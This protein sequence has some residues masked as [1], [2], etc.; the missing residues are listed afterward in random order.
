MVLLHCSVY[1]I[2][3]C[4]DGPMLAH[5]AE[6]E[7]ISTFSALILFV[8]CTKCICTPKNSSIKTVLPQQLLV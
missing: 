8:L 4:I 1:A 5:K 6:D 3:D 7:G 2:G